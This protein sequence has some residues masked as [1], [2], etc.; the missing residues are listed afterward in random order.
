MMEEVY[1]ARFFDAVIE[2]EITVFLLQETTQMC[3]SAIGIGSNCI[4]YTVS[5]ADQVTRSFWVFRPPQY[6]PILMPGPRRSS[7]SA[8]ISPAPSSPFD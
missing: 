2:E 7:L 8:P 6:L 3:I 4:D 1:Y 5:N